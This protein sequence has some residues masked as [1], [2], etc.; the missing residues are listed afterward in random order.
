MQAAT[1]AA[2][3]LK[4]FYSVKIVKVHELTENTF[5]KFIRYIQIL[6][7]SLFVYLFVYYGP[8]QLQ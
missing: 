4:R 5:V 1:F 3:A 2:F 6:K 8:H 7:T